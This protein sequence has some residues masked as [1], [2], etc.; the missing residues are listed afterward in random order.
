MAIHYAIIDV[1]Y[2]YMGSGMQIRIIIIKKQEVSSP[3]T[4][5]MNKQ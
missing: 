1:Q 2:M 3:F 4:F 5:H